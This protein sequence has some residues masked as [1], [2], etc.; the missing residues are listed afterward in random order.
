[1]NLTIA[2]TPVIEREYGGYHARICFATQDVPD[3]EKNL[4]E[5]I[6]AAYRRRIEQETK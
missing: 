6:M 2:E 1:M 4:L 3:A 5:L